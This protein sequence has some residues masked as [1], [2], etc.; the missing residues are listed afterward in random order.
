V[1][2]VVNG[3]PTAVADGTTVRALLDGLDVPGG[4]RGVAVAVDAAVVPRGEW[5]TTTLDD[6]AQVEILRAIQ[7]G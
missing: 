4:A 5:D 7:G 6:G 1:R 2:V 3:A